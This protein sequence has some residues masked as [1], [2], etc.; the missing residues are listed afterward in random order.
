MPMHSKKP[1]K[2][3]EEL[4]APKK[5]TPTPTEIR[6]MR[7]VI[8]SKVEDAKEIA[9]FKTLRSLCNEVDITLEK[10][11]CNTPAMIPVKCPYKRGSQCDTCNYLVQY[12]LKH[13]KAYCLKVKDI[14]VKE[15]D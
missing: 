7:L 1:R 11:F 15:K 9:I 3:L 4:N 13:Q 8:N 5:R 12:S 14:E 2:S 10:R 6:N